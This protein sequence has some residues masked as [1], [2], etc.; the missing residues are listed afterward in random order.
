MADQPRLLGPTNG[1]DEL[2]RELL[3]SLRDVSPPP[4]TKR[5]TW[6]RLAVQVAA[7]ATIGTTSIAVHAVGRSGAAAAIQ[8]TKMF[9]VK[10][11][12]GV[13]LAGS[14]AASGGWWLHEQT[15][16]K[17]A[18]RPPTERIA[19]PALPP[20]PTPP[21]PTPPPPTYEIREVVAPVAPTVAEPVERP[22]KNVEGRSRSDLLSL[23]SRLLTEAR[24]QL[25]G[26]DPRGALA[27]LER[28]RSRSP[29]GVLSQERD[30]LAIQIAS[31]L[32]DTATAKR[33]A[34]EFLDAYPESPHTPQ[35]RRLASDP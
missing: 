6:N 10:V 14:M 12:A 21:P 26:G 24:A 19:P 4:G 34:K 30:V 1:G 8:A 23:E 9:T 35:L 17:P 16:A 25:R 33:K 2:E 11:V 22:A 15:A 20:P 5:E 28:L 7:V 3:G 31:A 18:P 27:T 29:K 32:G 13:A